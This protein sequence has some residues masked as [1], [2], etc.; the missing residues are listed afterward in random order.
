MFFCYLDESGTPELAGNTSH[1][2]PGALWHAKGE[3]I[4]AIKQRFVLGT[5]KSIGRGLLI[6]TE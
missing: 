1:F 2:I 5:A 3:A 6:I 4:A